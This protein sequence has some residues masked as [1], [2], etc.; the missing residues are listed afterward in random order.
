MKILI[1]S[2]FYPPFSSVAGYRA[3]KI[4]RHLTDL[5]WEV[6]VLTAERDD[7]PSDL[8]VEIDP[9]RV[10]RT[11]FFDVNALPKAI[12][13]RSH[14]NRRGYEPRTRGPLAGLLGGL[15]RNV[16]NF[17]DGQIGWFR[18]AMRA[19]RGLLREWRPD[20]ILGIAS[21]WTALLVAH[22]LSAESGIP[23]VA[24]YQDP[25]TDAR[26]R[27][28][29]WPLSI[30]ERLIEDRTVGTASAIIGVSEA[31]ASQLQ[32]RFPDAPVHVV[33]CG[34]S[35]EEYVDRP[36]P[37]AWP[38][39]MA[40]TGRLYER[41]HPQP[42]FDAIASLLRTGAIG[43][44]DLRVEFRGRY[45]EVA[46]TALRRSVVD[47][48]VVRIGDPVAHHEAVAMQLRSHVLPLLLG[49]DDDVGW[50]PAKLYEYLAARRPIL[51]VGGSPA[52]EARRIVCEARA[53][54]AL[55]TTDQIAEQ[56]LSW[57]AELRATGRV[58]Y[59]G[60]D[61]IIEQFAWPTLVT[62]IAEVLEEVGG[63]A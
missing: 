49:D 19:A 18:P 8:P 54:V 5:G 38:L 21:P 11:S 29:I 7:L 40:Y 51:L 16:L 23:W 61:R 47:H 53:G 25:W 46:R 55:Q 13:G 33:A 43:G 28:R 45:L 58:A 56:I 59:S 27:D 4:S 10:V 63:K 12:L 24:E 48:P 9:A 57:I 44:D 52:H 22:A 20:A 14:V 50:R 26:S 30:A 60:D 6:R 34:Y 39:T 3:S 17:P 35:P 32:K 1:V 15:Y 37:P 42:L 62:R 31:W 2:F 36:L 41:Q